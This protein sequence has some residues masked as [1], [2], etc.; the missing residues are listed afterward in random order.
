MEGKPPQQAFGT[1]TPYVIWCHVLVA[2]L[3]EPVEPRI[4]E[5]A[6]CILAQQHAHF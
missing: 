1:V 6:R 4:R 3:M 2:L 5:S